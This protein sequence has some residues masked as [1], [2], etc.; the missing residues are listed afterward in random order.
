MDS[1]VPEIIFNYSE[2]YA[3]AVFNNAFMY[4]K[5]FAEEVR[6]NSNEAIGVYTSLWKPKGQTILKTLSEITG[7]EWREKTIVAYIIDQ[8][9]GYSSPLTIPANMGES[10]FLYIMTHE[11]T[12]RI[13]DQR[14]RAVEHYESWIKSKYPDIM[15]I[16][17]NHVL[18]HAIDTALY[19]KLF[20][21]EEL[22]EHRG[23][24]GTK[25]FGDPYVKAW[26]L[27][28]KEGYQEVIN[29]LKESKA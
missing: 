6:K 16:V 20:S 29:A 13:L 21:K 3:S 22:D 7:I 1:M 14:E 10:R 19:L 8:Y 9:R 23:I 11:L 4:S 27:V 5:G 25:K 18:V 15:P 28:D 24:D 2:L 12:H 26:E 17:R